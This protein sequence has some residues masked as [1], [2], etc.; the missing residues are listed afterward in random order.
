[1][2]AEVPD[3]LVQDNMMRRQMSEIL[4]RNVSNE[5]LAVGTNGLYALT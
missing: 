2:L 5:G 1:M 3:Q 4:M